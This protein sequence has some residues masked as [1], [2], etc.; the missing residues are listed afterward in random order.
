MISSENLG[1]R[2]G[3]HTVLWDLSLAIEEGSFVGILG[4]NGCGKTTFLRALSRILVTDS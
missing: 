4:P 2:Y 1:V 3:D